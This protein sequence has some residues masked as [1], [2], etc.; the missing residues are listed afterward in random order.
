MDNQPPASAPALQPL[1]VPAG[2]LVSWNTF[3]DL[4]VPAEGFGGSSLLYCLR[5][6][7]RLVVDVEWRP[8]D[9]PNGHY[10]YY[11]KRQPASREDATPDEILDSGESRSRTEV[12]AWAGRWLARGAAEAPG[13][14]SLPPAGFTPA[15]A[16]LHPLRIPG[17]W[18]IQR[19]LLTEAGAIPPDA[20]SAGRLLLFRAVDEQRGFRADVTRQAE[21][22]YALEVLH[23]PPKH[24]RLRDPIAPPD[25][26]GDAEV[27][28]RFETPAFGEVVT[29][30]EKW[31]GHAFWWAFTRPKEKR[32][33]G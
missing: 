14:V 32:R 16:S 19:N 17:G 12:A 9:D 29:R 30:L 22:G 18:T 33:Q 3:L 20:A 10:H 4:D 8:E 5:H 1:R 25:F 6:D 15:L 24:A 11:V 23:A 21:R 2:W 7:R 13:T 28:H 26:A 27:A 31:L